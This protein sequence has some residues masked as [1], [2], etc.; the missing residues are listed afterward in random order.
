MWTCHKTSR[1]WS[2]NLRCQTDVKLSTPTSSPKMYVHAPIKPFI[3][4]PTL[5]KLQHKKGQNLL[6]LK[7]Y[8]IQEKEYK[9]KPSTGLV[10]SRRKTVE[11]RSVGRLQMKSVKFLDKSKESWFCVQFLVESWGEL[12]LARGNQAMFHKMLLEPPANLKHLFINPAEARMRDDALLTWIF[13]PAMLLFIVLS[14]C[15]W[16]R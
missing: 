13:F 12:N 1:G 16:W 8:L 2:Y 3:P 10:S 6:L 9:K 4:L 14:S 7:S 11:G 5:P 15:S